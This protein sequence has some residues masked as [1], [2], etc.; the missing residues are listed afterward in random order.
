MIANNMV[1]KWFA[2]AHWAPSYKNAFAS[3]FFFIHV[4]GL[5]KLPNVSKQFSL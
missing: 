1:G 4:V 2:Q 5:G 3:T